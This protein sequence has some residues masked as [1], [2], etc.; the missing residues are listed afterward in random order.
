MRCQ[1]DCG[2]GNG[3]RRRRTEIDIQTDGKTNRFFS[4]F[5]TSI[6]E[7]GKHNKINETSQIRHFMTI[8]YNQTPADWTEKNEFW[9]E[10]LKH[11]D[12]RPNWESGK[13]P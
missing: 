1:E 12:T 11:V 4:F 5:L 9:D 10:A 8:H 2:V 6:Q 3:S 7:R 13:I